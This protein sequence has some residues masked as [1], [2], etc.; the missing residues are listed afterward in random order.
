MVVNKN[1]TKSKIQK[2]KTVGVWSAITNF[3][4]NYANF[5]GTAQR[6]E[7]F[8]AILFVFLVH[9]MI[10]QVDMGL[11]TWHFVSDSVALILWQ[12]LNWV[13]VIWI[14][15]TFIPCM[16][17]LERRLHDA[18]LPGNWV[19]IP[20][21]V[22]WLAGTLFTDLAPWYFLAFATI[23]SLLPGKQKNNKYRK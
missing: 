20:V 22:L 14:V 11:V 8:F 4:K 10:V 16:A 7:C 21:L 15:G 5:K 1:K 6:G 18:G 13:R 3:W 19:W 2:Q 12:M 9:L 17:L 23:I